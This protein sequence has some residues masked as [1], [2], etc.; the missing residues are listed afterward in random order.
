MKQEGR[1]PRQ[2]GFTEFFAVLIAILVVGVG[3]YYFGYQAAQKKQVPPAI[4]FSP[5]P[6]I[7]NGE[8]TN[9]KT[10]TNSKYKITFNYPDSWIVGEDNGEKSRGEPF[11][12]L[13]RS[14]LQT[15]DKTYGEVY[16]WI[17]NDIK[18]VEQYIAKL[19][20]SPGVCVS[21]DNVKNIK[22]ANLDAF[23]I[24]NIP[25]PLPSEEVV[26]KEGDLLIAFH[27]N[28]QG[29][30]YNNYSNKESKQIFDQIL[31]TFKFLP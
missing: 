6:T 1:F 20:D 13:R 5:S 30:N 23:N 4:Q 14:S 25:A 10:Y 27:F 16:I 28:Y 26:F 29:E 17:Y 22:V 8:T 31:S 12:F 15:Q 9:W 21:S 19:C 24:K 2:A 18:T 7:Q 3:A 11:I